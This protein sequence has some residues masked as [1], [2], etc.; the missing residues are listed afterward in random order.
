MVTD[1][2]IMGSERPLRSGGR[3]TRAES[4]RQVSVTS[5][6]YHQFER[7]FYSFTLPVIA[8]FHE[9]TL[10]GLELCLKE[11]ASTISPMRIH[12]NPAFEFVWGGC[13]R[14]R[15]T[16]APPL[17]VVKLCDKSSPGV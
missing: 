12:Q 14:R 6:I 3:V 11:G 13:S 10:P 17:S 2:P 9:R 4:G 7:A 15:S 1:R 16:A 5:T 8:L